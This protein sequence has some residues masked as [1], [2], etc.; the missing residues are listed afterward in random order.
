MKFFK[1]YFD[2]ISKKLFL[3]DERKFYQLV[4]ELIKTKKAKKKVILYG[5]GGSA[6]MASHLS[7]T[8]V[9]IHKTDL[10]GTVHYHQPL[11]QPLHA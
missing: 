4:D 2:V 3:E 1:R 5:N 11:P 6:A 8:H 10:S 9:A 7:T